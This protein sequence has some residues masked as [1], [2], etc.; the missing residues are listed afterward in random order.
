MKVAVVG[1]G[2]AGATVAWQLSERGH[3]VT[4]FE[5]AQKCGPV[6]A[7]ILLQPSGQRVLRQ[8]GLLEAVI[9][10]SARIDSLHARHRTGS[11]L[12]KLQYSRLSPTLTGYGVR[13][14]L[15]FDLLLQRCRASGVRICEGQ[16]IESAVQHSGGVQLSMGEGQTDP[17]ELV[18]AADGSR[19]SLRRQLGQTERITEY[20]DAALWTLGPYDGDPSCLLQVAGRCGRLIGMLPVGDG[21]CSFFWGLK[22]TEE[23]ELRSRGIE[24]WKQQVADFF[25]AASSII[26]PLTSLEG[27]PF[28]TYRT[29]TM[30][31]M[32]CERIV[33]A[34]D[35]GH[36][37]SP[38][39][40]QG[41][42]LALED[43]TALVAAV[44]RT[45]DPAAA[46]AA[47]D[48]QRRRKTRFYTQLTGLL[49]PFFQTSSRVLQLGRDLTLPVMPHLPYVG[50]Q[51]VLTMAGL[52]SG[53]LGV[54]PIPQESLF[55]NDENVSI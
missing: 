54:E 8:L 25:P 16:R 34:G 1:C 28:A 3:Q 51:M 7:G 14:S 36:P 17:F 21:Q 50:R 6:G 26:A 46:I 18:V 53:W 52:K 55:E 39:L 19:S 30:R 24:Y 45:S 15:L 32:A 9:D 49:T 5:Q 27:V 11:T 31:T 38:H 41:L 37:T 29:I 13:R 43:A 2:I 42:N 23:R 12:V 40:G 33:F 22:K 10:Q 20:A 44:D 35:A 4:V 47:F 48:Q